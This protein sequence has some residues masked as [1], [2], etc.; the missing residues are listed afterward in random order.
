MIYECLKDRTIA[1]ID[2]SKDRSD[3]SSE[4]MTKLFDIYENSGHIVKVSDVDLVSLT[5]TELYKWCHENTEGNC[6]VSF[7]IETKGNILAHFE[8]E[9]DAFAFK[10]RW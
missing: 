5:E 1:I 3:L 6:F 10:L 4:Q 2:S 9:E 7:L 8:L